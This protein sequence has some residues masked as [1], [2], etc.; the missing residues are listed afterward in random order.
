VLVSSDYE[1]LLS[2]FAAIDAA[3]AGRQENVDRKHRL[4]RAIHDPTKVNPLLYCLA[5]GLDAADALAI[6]GST[7]SRHYKLASSVR[8]DAAKEVTISLV[9]LVSVWPPCSLGVE[10]YG[11][12]VALCGK[13][14]SDKRDVNLFSALGGHRDS[15]HARFRMRLWELAGKCAEADQDLHPVVESKLLA[16]ECGF[17]ESLAG[18]HARSAI[19]AS[20]FP[21]GDGGST[22]KLYVRGRFEPE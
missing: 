4:L 21:S 15:D 12:T 2:Y 6:C 19:L 16:T 18:S 3:D 5:T 20:V 13:F 22:L 1:R 14:S 17:Q 9:E 8:E 11:R 7:I 10:A